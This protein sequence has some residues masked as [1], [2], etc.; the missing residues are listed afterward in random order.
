MLVDRYRDAEIILLNQEE[1]LV[2]ACDSC[3]AIG[4]KEQDQ[5]K[6]SHYIVGKYTA[7]VSLMEVLSLGA[8][9][10]SLTVNICNEPYPTGDEILKGIQSELKTCNIEVPITV[11]TEKNISTTMTALGVTVIGIGKRKDLKIDRAVKQ[12]FVYV[13]GI[14]KLGNEVVEDEGEITDTHVLL[15]LL[16]DP[17]IKEIIPVGSSGIQGEIEKLL[18]AKKLYMTY[19]ED[20]SLDFNKSAGPCTAVIVIS[21]RKLEESYGLPQN[22][23]GKLEEYPSC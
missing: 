13:F 22:F 21:E 23:I 10:I 7:R 3:G 15:Q 2:I 14:P 17:Y 11:S 9:V 4:I 6:A 19:R 20:G 12:D 16:K 5:V 8:K 1:V 18:R